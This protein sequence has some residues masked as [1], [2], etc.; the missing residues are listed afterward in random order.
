M[1]SSLDEEE[2]SQRI[3]HPISQVCYEIIREIDTVG[4][5][6]FECSRYVGYLM[7]V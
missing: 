4:T 3:L 1:D 5:T 7:S 6:V 2:V